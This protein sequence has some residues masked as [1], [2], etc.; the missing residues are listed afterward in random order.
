MPSF[1]DS[2]VLGVS[3]RLQQAT[4]DINKLKEIFKV[5]S[6]SF[7]VVHQ[8]KVILKQ[9]IG[10]R[11]V[12]NRLN[13]DPDTIYPISSCTKMF[14]AA[15]IALLVDEEKLQWQDQVSTHLPEFNPQGNPAIA[16]G[17]DL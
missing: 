11:D 13:A 4:S 8:G 14:T 15:G 2:D 17:S 16:S 10:Y 3:K 9:S 5:P 7:G 6:I 12:H 1:N